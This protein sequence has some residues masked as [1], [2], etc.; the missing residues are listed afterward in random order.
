MTTEAPGGLRRTTTAV[1]VSALLAMGVTLIAL[2]NGASPSVPAA[3]PSAA[4]PF[5]FSGFGTA[6]I[7]VLWA[8]EGWQYVTFSAGEARDPQ[9]TFPRALATATAALIVIYL[10]ASYGYIAALGAEAAS[11]SDHIAADAVGA[12][13]GTA[14][15]KLVGALILVSVFSAATAI[16]AVSVWAALLAVSGTFEQLL[17]AV[18][19]TGWIFYG[20]GGLA[21]MQLRRLEPSAPRPFRVPGYPITPLLFVAS[22][23]VLVGN[24]LIA[25]PERAAAGLG[26]VLLGTPAFFLWRAKSRRALTVSSDSPMER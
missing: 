26:V 13:L 9:R 5:P 4:S 21:V 3:N 19:F 20:L 7:G 12:S 1:K 17:T 8:Y 24:T 15:G 22:A 11:R 25:Q 18:V 14:A 16:V 6:M 23:A 2:G 10:L